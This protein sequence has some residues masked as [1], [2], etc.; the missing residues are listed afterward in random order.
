M[1]LGLPLRTTN[2]IVE[3]YGSERF[4]QLVDPARLDQT[5]L[6]DGLGV[7]K[8]REGHDVGLEPVSIKRG[9]S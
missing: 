5:L 6:A 2:T 7:E 3:V 9:P 1:P 4:G 8:G